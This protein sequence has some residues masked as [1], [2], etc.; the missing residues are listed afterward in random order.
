M[1]YNLIRIGGTKYFFLP[2]SLFFRATACCSKRIRFNVK[3]TFH[4]DGPFYFYSSTKLDCFLRPRYRRCH[5]SDIRHTESD[6]SSGSWSPLLLNTVS[7]VR[8]PSSVLTLDLPRNAML[9]QFFSRLKI[10]S[11][12][13]KYQNVSFFLRSFPFGYHRSQLSSFQYE[14]IA[15]G[16]Y[17]FEAVLF[18]PSLKRFLLSRWKQLKN[19]LARKRSC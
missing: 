18:F 7:L 19:R 9:I 16:I 6:G 3:E 12:L 10:H 14:R 2:L 11:I 8:S 13:R 5:L 1:S 4:D 15:V 17:N